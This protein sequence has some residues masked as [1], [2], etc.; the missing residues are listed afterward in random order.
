MDIESIY[1]L[2]P[3]A[4]GPCVQYI[5]RT[6]CFRTLQQPGLPSLT[7]ASVAWKLGMFVGQEAL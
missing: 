3:F 6:L 2:H 4:L 5:W 1:L 7:I